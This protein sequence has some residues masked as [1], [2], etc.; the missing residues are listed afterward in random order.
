MANKIPTPAEL[1]K[2]IGEFLKKKY[3][4]NIGIV[5]PDADGGDKGT[6]TEKERKRSSIKSDMKP[7]ELEAYLNTY[8]IKQDGAKEILSTKICTHFNRMN[9]P[10]E[11]DEAFVG[12]IKNNIIMIGPT[13][14][15]K[16]YLIKLIARTIGVPFVK[17]D[18]TKFSETGYVGGDVEDLVRDLVREAEGDIDLAQHGII[19]VDEIDK[20]ASSGSVTGPDVSRTG[21]QRTLLK[22]MEET[23]VDLKAPHDFAAQM[24]SVMQFQKTGKVERKK[25]NTRN[26]LFIVSGAFSE[27]ED[28]IRRR[29]NRQNMG[30]RGEPTKR[31]EGQDDLFRQVRAEDLIAYGFE[32]EFVGRLPVIAVL[33]ELNMDDLYEILRTPH[34]SVISGKRRDFK[35][36]GIELEFEDDALR[37]LAEKAHEERTGARGLASVCEK[38]LMKF[39]KKLPSTDIKRLVV[40]K[41]VVQDPEGELTRVLMRRAVTQYQAEFYR[42]YEI[43]L[44]FGE[45]ALE[46]IMARA[47]SE[48]TDIATYC[49]GLL[50]DYGHGLKLV[51]KRE[52]EIT[53]DIVECPKA[54]LD[55]MIKQ[56]YGAH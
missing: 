12:H 43:R 8:V 18:A 48:G 35:A 19:Y 7:E 55:K 42:N 40:T 5:Q 56:F 2:E 27:L 49:R 28:I 11:D 26:I 54:C 9:L 46:L 13:G 44:S 3:G 14:V 41:P 4:T 29:L 22:L 52:L 24:E 25:I 37:L 6:E 51:E 1:Q 17:G 53:R 38:V 32:S 45:D 34:S 23:E 15:G 10:E 20:I 50:T 47:R 33:E 36:Y 21:V 30:F 39:E 31:G 16:T